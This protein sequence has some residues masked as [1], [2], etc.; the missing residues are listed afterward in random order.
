MRRASTW[1]LSKIL[2]ESKRKLCPLIFQTAVGKQREIHCGCRVCHCAF[3]SASEGGEMRSKRKLRYESTARCPRRPGTLFPGV[4]TALWPNVQFC[5]RLRCLRGAARLNYTQKRK[6]AIRYCCC[7]CCCS[8]IFDFN[9]WSISYRLES[10]EQW[11][12]GKKK[13]K[14]RRNEKRS[15]TIKMKINESVEA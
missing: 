7:C 11:S 12:I 14:E 6:R 9:F 10:S 2:V 5:A 15:W 13:E 1:L 8:V 4:C 3:R